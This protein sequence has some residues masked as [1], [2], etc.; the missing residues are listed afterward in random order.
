MCGRFNLRL[1]PAE[2]QEFFRLVDAPDDL[3]IRYNIAPTQQILT[4][5]QREGTQQ[6]ATAAWGL[7]PSWNPAQLLINA[8]SESVFETR[9]FSK[10]IR[11]RRCLVPASGFYEWLTIGKE[12]FPYHITLRSGEPLTFAGLIDAAGAVALM[13]TSPNAEMAE[14]HD[15][16]P[17][18][19]AR[20][21]WEHYLD[22]AV[23]DPAEITP[24]LIP[25]PD[26]SLSLTP[27]DPVVNNARNE[28]PDCLRQAPRTGGTLF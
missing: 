13:T 27:V 22:P 10:S 21:V 8:R 7:R 16:M 23:T 17:V 12:K 15:R 24:L 9:A 11:E 14:I 19:L 25:L 6:W 5:Q 4:I 18:I 3:G 28:T 1:T 26:D 2:L 20:P